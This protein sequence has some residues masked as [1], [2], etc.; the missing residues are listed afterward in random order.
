[1][2]RKLTQT[3]KKTHPPAGQSIDNALQTDIV[4]CG[5]VYHE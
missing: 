1:M 5:G 4:K 2:M 3:K